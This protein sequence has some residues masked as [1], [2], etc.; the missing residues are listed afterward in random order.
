MYLRYSLFSILFILIQSLPTLADM[1]KAER[2][3]INKDFD[4]AYDEFIAHANNGNAR[5]QY[6]I[7]TMY[8]RGEG[9]IT[10]VPEAIKWLT[11]AA[12]Q[13]YVKA[14]YSLGYMHLLG[15]V[16]PKDLVEAQKWLI[17]AAEND[18]PQSQHFLA[19]TYMY[20][21]YG[22]KIDIIKALKFLTQAAEN[23]YND[24]QYMLGQIYENGINVPVD[25]EKAG[26]WYRKSADQEDA[27]AMLGLARLYMGGKGV[28]KDFAIAIEHASNSA[29]L[30]N[31]DAFEA[32]SHRARKDAVFASLCE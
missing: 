5:A 29:N 25:Y 14:Q 17:L 31:P 20:K 15:N 7:G 8:H 13:N 11:K 18:D 19:L 10:D 21:Q 30:G 1:D 28:P 22:P 32:I 9:T 12:D 2:D 6:V 26:M 4:A 23:G 24:S 16:I 3:L 27:G